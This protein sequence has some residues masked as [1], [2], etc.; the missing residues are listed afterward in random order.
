MFSWESAFTS[1]PDISS[2]VFSSSSWISS[3]RGSRPLKIQLHSSWNKKIIQCNAKFIHCLVYLQRPKF[4]ISV[5]IFSNDIF[6]LRRGEKVGLIDCLQNRGV[7][8]EHGLGLSRHTGWLADLTVEWVSGR[9]LESSRH[10]ARPH[11]GWWCRLELSGHWSCPGHRAG[12][13]KP[14]PS[15]ALQL[16]IPVL[17]WDLVSFIQ[18]TG[19]WI[20]Y[21][22]CRHFDCSLWDSVTFILS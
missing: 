18:K 8:T 6:R 12:S 9:S 17:L 11:E 7:R 3:G 10:R 4:R 5:F 16:D 15:I 19:D 2:R 13:S 14:V 21:G 1:S 20:S 22:V